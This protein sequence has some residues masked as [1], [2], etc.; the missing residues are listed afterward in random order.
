MNPEMIIMALK[1][2]DMGFGALAQYNVTEQAYIDLRK[3]KGGQL[4]MEDLQP[5][6]DKAQKDIDQIGTPNG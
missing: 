1:L 4:T 2:L 6:F 3:A 5:L